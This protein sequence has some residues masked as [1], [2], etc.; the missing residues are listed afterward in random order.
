VSTDPVAAHHPYEFSLQRDIFDIFHPSDVPNKGD[1]R[2]SP[3]S[4]PT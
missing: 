1:G 2:S 4:W 3:N